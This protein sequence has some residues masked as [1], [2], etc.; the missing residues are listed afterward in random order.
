MNCWGEENILWREGRDEIFGECTYWKEERGKR[1]R[2]F[3]F[4]PAKQQWKSMLDSI[5]ETTGSE[6]ENK[7]NKKT[8]K[9]KI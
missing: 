3:T 7:N 8:M 1:V 6:C 2:L 9:I 5:L 4:Q